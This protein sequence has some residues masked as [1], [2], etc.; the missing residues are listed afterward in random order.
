MSL[1]KPLEM[2]V[3]KISKRNR[4]FEFSVNLLR[5]AFYCY[6]ISY[7]YFGSVSPSPNTQPLW[8]VIFLNA[9]FL[10]SILIFQR[11][12]DPSNKNYV[13]SISINLQQLITIVLISIF[14]TAL[15]HEKLGY[16]LFGDELAYSGSALGH[17]ILAT[18][19]AIEWAHLGDIPLKFIVQI[20]NI[21]LVTLLLILWKC[22]GDI[23]SKK[24]FIFI[25]L[26]FL[27]FRIAFILKGGN[28]N[29]HPP[30]A[31]LPPLISSTIF[32]VSELGLKLSYFA[33][34]LFYLFFISIT[35]A[36]IAGN[37]ILQI[38]AMLAIATIPLTLDMATVIDH[39]IFGYIFI[40]ALL[41]Y[42][43]TNSHVNY[44]AVFTL[45]TIGAFFRQPIILFC[46]P[47][48]LLYINEHRNSGI[49][50]VIIGCIKLMIPCLLFLPIVLNSLINGTPATEKMEGA[51]N[52][53]QLIAA[54]HSNFIVEQA[55]K[56]FQPHLL[57]LFVLFFIP[58][59]F[60]DITKKVIYL[61]YFL[62]LLIIYFS[63]NE[64][65]WSYPKYQAEYIA[66]FIACSIIIFSCLTLKGAL[67]I[68]P[69]CIT[70]L[71]LTLNL[72]NFALP[73]KFRLERDH[74]SINYPYREAYKKIADLGLSDATYSV[75]ITYGSLTELLNSYSGN[76]WI[77]A[78]KKY[79]YIRDME[80][81]SR[82]SEKAQAI[83]KIQNNS[84]LLIQG[85]IN[86]EQIIP[87]ITA[88][89]WKQMD[90]FQS[91]PTSPKIY[92][93]IKDPAYGLQNEH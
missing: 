68:I 5:V 50:K 9:C 18:S 83:N 2:I 4:D 37:K 8:F 53:Q 59:T 1:I 62:L 89:G 66:P 63:I 39:S 74:I 35:L 43:S 93:Y 84:A 40:S 45:I 13:I 64:G 19:N 75:G 65:L 31:R 33:S 15:I 30:M 79:L 6:L 29:P 20:V 26:F 54:I 72:C 61:F 27:A 88:L 49:G 7:G 44:S 67:E 21:F 82:P 58:A 28:G 17:S 41:I 25:L 81:D 90:L 76:S 22:T 91:S 51:I 73:E 80:F 52:I 57:I 24:K 71:I 10:A 56:I 78:Q 87:Y 14:S 47:T 70:Y 12:Y 3:Y 42:F 69:I 11:A 36:K 86:S 38:G 55:I 23:R 60:K 77:N 85:H 34:Y 46:A 48:L 92:L 32:G 16:S